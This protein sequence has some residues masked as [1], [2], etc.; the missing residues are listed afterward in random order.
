ML[1][2]LGLENYI[3][4]CDDSTVFISTFW[5]DSMLTAKQSQDTHDTCMQAEWQAIVF[6]SP[7]LV[8]PFPGELYSRDSNNS[9]STK[10]W[11]HSLTTPQ[12]F[13]RDSHK[14]WL[15][16]RSP[17]TTRPLKEAPLS[18]SSS[19]ADNSFY[20]FARSGRTSLSKCKQ[21]AWNL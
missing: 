15:V 21:R 11:C 4:R 2:L 8:S 13:Q 5:R 6:I 1:G 9:C 16:W 12:C 7:S 10:N 17:L 20:L 14:L 3:H 18:G 19:R